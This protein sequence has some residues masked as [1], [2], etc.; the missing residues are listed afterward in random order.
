MGGLTVNNTQ[1]L[2]ELSLLYHLCALTAPGAAWGPF[3]AVLAAAFP[4]GRR[5]KD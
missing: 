2:E 5:G 4:P 1:P 3:T